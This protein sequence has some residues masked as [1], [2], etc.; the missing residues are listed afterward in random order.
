MNISST[1]AGWR[2]RALA[3]EV[4]GRAACQAALR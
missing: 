3:V 1:S 2:R 4:D